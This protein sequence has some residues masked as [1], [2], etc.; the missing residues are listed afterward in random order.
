MKQGQNY[1]YKVHYNAR[2]KAKRT[3][4]TSSRQETRTVSE[5]CYPFFPRVLRNMYMCGRV[6]VRACGGRFYAFR[7]P[8]APL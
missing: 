7:P 5:S 4:R 1:Y 3:R 6:F 8:L 2:Q